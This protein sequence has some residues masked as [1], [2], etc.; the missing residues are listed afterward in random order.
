MCDAASGQAHTAHT[1]NPVPL[2]YIGRRAGQFRLKDGRL[3]D[4]APTLLQLM[5]LP[6]P[7]EME[8]TSLLSD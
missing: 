3:C 5:G 2:I 4:I 7:Q 6:V 1:L 8:G